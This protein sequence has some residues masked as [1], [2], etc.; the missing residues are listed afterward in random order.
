MVLERAAQNER[1]VGWLHQQL[2]ISVAA[3]LAV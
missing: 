2:V 1:V 3:C